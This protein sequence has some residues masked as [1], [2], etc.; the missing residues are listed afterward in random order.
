MLLVTA[1]SGSYSFSLCEI[2]LNIYKDFNVIS[3]FWLSWFRWAGRLA[4]WVLCLE[5]TTT[6]TWNSA[7]RKGWWPVDML[8]HCLND[9]EKSEETA[10][11]W[12]A[13]FIDNSVDFED[14]G[15]NL[16]DTTFKLNQVL[17]KMKLLLSLRCSMKETDSISVLL[18]LPLEWGIIVWMIIFYHTLWMYMYMNFVLVEKKIQ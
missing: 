8:I 3:I 6:S 16:M 13:T 12:K 15:V 4:V 5:Q 9:S 7:G 11:N 18:S 2:Y 14:I 1:D 10:S 17:R